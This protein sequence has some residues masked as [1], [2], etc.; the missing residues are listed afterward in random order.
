MM[1]E[2]VPVTIVDPQE[3]LTAHNGPR[4]QH[5]VGGLVWDSNLASYAANWA[6]QCNFDHSGGCNYLWL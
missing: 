2:P 3:A 4:G 1:E 6:G 5:G